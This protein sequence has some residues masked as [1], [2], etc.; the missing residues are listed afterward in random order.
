MEMKG[1]VRTL[2]L[3]EERHSA[4]WD[5]DGARENL[6]SLDVMRSMED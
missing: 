6:T 3:N 4:A 2:G 1:L 5:V